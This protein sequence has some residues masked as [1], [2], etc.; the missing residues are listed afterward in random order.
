MTIHGFELAE[1]IKK[2]PFN[3]RPLTAM[4]TTAPELWAAVLA[5]LGTE[6]DRA[7]VHSIFDRAVDETMKDIEAEMKARVGENGGGP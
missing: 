6:S 7:A 1:N 2:Q 5:A 3:L 4:P